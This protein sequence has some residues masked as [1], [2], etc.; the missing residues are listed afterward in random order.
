MCYLVPSRRTHD[1]VVTSLLRQNDFAMS[2]WRN[3]AV[4]IAS[5][6]YWVGYHAII[7]N[8]RIINQSIRASVDEKIFKNALILMHGKVIA[9]LKNH[10]MQLL[11]HVPY[12]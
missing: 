6:V 7:F 10:G 4:I 3:N 8:A 12:A 11:I 5:R 9:S 2:L 1:A